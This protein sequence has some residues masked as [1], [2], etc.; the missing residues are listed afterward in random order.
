[1][2]CSL[3]YDNKNRT[4]GH[5]RSGADGNRPQHLHGHLADADS[6]GTLMEDLGTECRDPDVRGSLMEHLSSERREPGNRDASV[7]DLGAESGETISCH[8]DTTS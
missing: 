2:G 8:Y 7:E 3:G 6:R 5:T 4:C 1:M